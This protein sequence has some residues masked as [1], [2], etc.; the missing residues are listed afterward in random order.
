MR[1]VVAGSSGFLG[2]ALRDRL[3]REGHEV[4]R[5]V[6]GSASTAS[7][8][9]WDPYLGTVDD[10]VIASADVVVNLGGV[11]IAHW[12]WTET[13]KRQIRDSREA[14]T[15]TLAGAVARTGGHAALVNASGINAY[16]HP[17]DAVRD[18]TSPRGDGFLAEVVR[19]W[20]D[21]TSPAM[22]AG[23]RVVM[24]R[25][26]V[27]LHGSGG[28]LAL[29]KMPFL[30][31]VGGRVGSGKQWFSWISLADWVS[32]VVFLSTSQV[33]GPVNLVAPTP[34]TNAEFTKAMGKVLRRPTRFP[35][36]GL[37]MRLVGGEVASESL[38]SLRV[39]PTV[40]LAAGF[41]FEH[42]D[43]ESALRYAF[44]R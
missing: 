25:S 5:L 42:P 23:A 8:S 6:R 22:K 24:L 38:D 9:S 30:L 31:G 41:T 2:T 13:Y 34:V 21:A 33:S 3:A 17:G 32:A 1:V 4:R 20:E 40:L 11:P 44:D 19:S 26:G 18:E 27:V 12:P 36:P 29:M 35:V 16:G 7:E 43:I 10:D 28:A 37:P 39:V 15:G 14:T